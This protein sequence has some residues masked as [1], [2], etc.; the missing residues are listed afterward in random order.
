MKSF[1]PILVETVAKQDDSLAHTV[2]T[3]FFAAYLLI[4]FIES[5]ACIF[6]GYRTSGKLFNIH[7]LLPDSK[8]IMSLIHDLY[9]T[10]NFEI[11]TQNIFCSWE[12]DS[13][14][15]AIRI[16]MH[17]SPTGTTSKAKRWKSWTLSLILTAT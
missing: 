5:D 10:D 14:H 3:I 4:A 13:S 8:K 7:R 9:Y 11:I 6:I 1:C 12:T 2:F 17:Q 15:I 16:I